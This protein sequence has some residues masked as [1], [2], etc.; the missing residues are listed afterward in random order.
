M[1]SHKLHNTWALRYGVPPWISDAVNKL[2]DCVQLRDPEERKRCHDLGLTK[3][4]KLNIGGI[5][6]PLGADVT[7]VEL[8]GEL[9][10]LFAG[11]D[12]LHAV[13]AALL[14]H[15]LDMIE[16][17]IRELGEKVARSDPELIVDRAYKKML[18]H[19]LDVLSRGGSMQYTPF[20]RGM[21]RRWSRM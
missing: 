15:F 16:R 5:N 13:R 6:I 11:D 10:R 18:K 9:R 19:S 14:H 1:P 20:S 17:Q 21:R 7:V 4:V 12:F 3:N 8:Y 2:I